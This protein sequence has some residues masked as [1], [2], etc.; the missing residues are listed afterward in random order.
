MRRKSAAIPEIACL[1]E[2]SH[3]EFTQDDRCSLDFLSADLIESKNKLR[4]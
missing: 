4:R 1:I 3:A 2:A